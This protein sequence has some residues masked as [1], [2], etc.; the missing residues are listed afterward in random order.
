MIRSEQGRAAITD[1]ALADDCVA[2]ARMFFNRPDF[3]LGSAHPPTFALCSEGEMFDALR[4]DY[5]AMSV[6]IFGEPP[7]F[8]AIIEEVAELERTLNGQAQ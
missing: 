1:R 3:D 8:D 5:R 6:M 7:S 4:Q 2:H